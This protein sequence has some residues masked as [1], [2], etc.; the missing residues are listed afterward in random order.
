MPRVRTSPSSPPSSASLTARSGSAASGVL[1]VISGAAGGGGGESSGPP[2]IS[3]AS[4]NSWADAQP[5]SANRHAAAQ[6]TRTEI[7]MQLTT[8]AERA[9]VTQHNK[10]W[11]TE[12][13]SPRPEDR[14]SRGK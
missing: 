2:G 3:D 6:R 11:E 13:G 7:R 10:L 1:P 5:A 12:R 9:G 14:R 8:P 4:L